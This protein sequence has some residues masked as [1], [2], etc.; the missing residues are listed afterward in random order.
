[1]KY[2]VFVAGKK[3]EVEVEE[4]DRNTFEVII[5]DKRVIIKIEG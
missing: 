4:V 3:F 5:N 1:M 2:E